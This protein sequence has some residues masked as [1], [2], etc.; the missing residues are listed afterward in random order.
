MPSVPIEIKTQIVKAYQSGHSGSLENTAALFGVSLSTV[1]R[2]LRRFRETK[3]VKNKP[4][5]GMRPRAVDLQWLEEHAKANPDARLTDRI[6]DWFE[7]S[8]N[9]V[10]K[11]TMSQSMK[12]IGWTY[13]KNSWS[14]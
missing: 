3:S 10:C 1:Q 2:T 9:R 6:K 13:K 5:G 11:T 7:H 14:P 8:G 12:A 4:K